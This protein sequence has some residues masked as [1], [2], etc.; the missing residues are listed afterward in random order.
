LEELG[1]T[2]VAETDAVA[3]VGEFERRKDVIDLVITDKT[4]PQ[5]T[6]L[7]VARAIRAIRPDV[8]VILC[9]GFQTVED[10]QAQSDLGILH[11]INKP[12]MKHVMAQKVREVLNQKQRMGETQV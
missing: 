4:M 8:P 1:Y 2:V 12:I 5:M 11:F 7:D 9:S 10:I 3:A 6:G